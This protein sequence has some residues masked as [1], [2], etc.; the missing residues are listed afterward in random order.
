MRRE[1]ADRVHGFERS[2]YGHR[3]TVIGTAG[4]LIRADDQ[5]RRCGHHHTLVEVALKGAGEYPYELGSPSG[6]RRCDTLRDLYVLNR[7]GK[8]AA[9]PEAAIQQS[10]LPLPER[11]RRVKHRAA[12]QPLKDRVQHDI[13]RG[14]PEAEICDL[15]V[16]VG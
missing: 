12:D 3:N 15:H 9:R 6:G 8:R 4:D 13:S 2:F 5:D 14:T 11:S 1:I 16:R 7:I 10:S